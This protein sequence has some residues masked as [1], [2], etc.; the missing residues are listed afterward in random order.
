[1]FRTLMIAAIAST[2]LGPICRASED[3]QT[4]TAM[5]AEEA[6]LRKYLLA[7]I[8]RFNKHELRPA[9]SPGFTPDADFVNV[10]GRWMRGV[11]EIRRVHA[12]AAQGWLKDANIKLIE[13]DIRFIRPDV[14]V[15]HQLHEMSGSRHPNGTLLAPHQQISTRILVKEQGQWITT[16]FQNTMV[17]ARPG[18]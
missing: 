3:A 10:E 15:V 7:I 1:M 9:T 4:K 13:L 17:D 2:L 6:E 16:A 14:A 18:R 12:V 11:E 8:D 5:N